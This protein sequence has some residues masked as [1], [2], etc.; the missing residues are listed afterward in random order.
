MGRA[1]AG[2]EAKRCRL[3]NCR[4]YLAAGIARHRG[5]LVGA[6]FTREQRIWTAQPK[7]NSSMYLMFV[8][9]PHSRDDGSSSSYTTVFSAIPR[10]V[11]L[12]ASS[13]SACL[14]AC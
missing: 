11:R 12:L 4:D 5:I 6:P 9:A 2:D 14:V 3:R 13:A 10:Q 8:R 7:G 1:E